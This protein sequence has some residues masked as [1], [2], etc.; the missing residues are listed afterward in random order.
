M[1]S[2]IGRVEKIEDF[3]EKQN[4]QQKQQQQHEKFRICNEIEMRKL[5]AARRERLIQQYHEVLK[6]E[7]EKAFEL[8]HIPQHQYQTIYDQLL[9]IC[10]NCELSDDEALKEIVFVINQWKGER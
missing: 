6:A 2:E 5:K 1:F 4:L 9:V 3:R 8:S 7:A 10:V